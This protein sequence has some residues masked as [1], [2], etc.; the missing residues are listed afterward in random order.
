M[1][2]QEFEQKISRLEG[3]M[4]DIIDFITEI[5]EED[6]SFS[7]K[8]NSYYKQELFKNDDFYMKK[9][10][11]EGI[12]WYN[13]INDND[14]LQFV[15]NLLHHFEV[16]MDAD[17]DTKIFIENP[18]ID[19]LVSAM[20]GLGVIF[21]NKKEPKIMYILWEYLNNKTKPIELRCSA[22]NALLKIYGVPYREIFLRSD[23]LIACR[24]EKYF[25]RNELAFN[26][27]F[28]EIKKMLD[29]KSN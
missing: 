13:Q 3:D 17:I 4:F 9:V 21:T 2:E 12:W 27:E 23:N 18:K 28:N 22:Q 14:V 5:M 6:L 10:C 7:K 11:I 16:N 1:T 25:E 20:I 24:D 26:K 15:I 8:I 29:K 19:F